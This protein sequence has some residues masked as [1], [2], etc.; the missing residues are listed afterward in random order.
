MSFINVKQQNSKNIKFKIK[1]NKD[2][3]IQIKL[4]KNKAFFNEII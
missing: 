1:L 4:Y 3:K 2:I